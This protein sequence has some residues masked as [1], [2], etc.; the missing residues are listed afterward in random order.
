MG[1]YNFKAAKAANKNFNNKEK[2]ALAILILG[3]IAG[4]VLTIAGIGFIAGL[5]VAGAAISKKVKLRRE[6]KMANRNRNKKRRF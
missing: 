3:A 6:A 1:K 2:I 5:A 4:I